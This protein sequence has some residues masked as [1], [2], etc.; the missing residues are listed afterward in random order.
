MSPLPSQRTLQ[1]K[2]DVML[3]RPAG[4][5]G[6]GGSQTSASLEA[7]ISNIKTTESNILHQLADL[8]YVHM[9][10]TFTTKNSCVCVC[11][12][13]MG[14]DSNS[15]A[16]RHWIG[17]LHR[18]QRSRPLSRCSL[19]LRPRRWCRRT[20]ATWRTS[21]NTSRSGD[22]SA[23]WLAHHARL[24]R[25][26]LPDGIA[27]PQLYVACGT[28][29]PRWSA[30]RAWGGGVE[31]GVGLGVYIVTHSSRGGGARKEQAI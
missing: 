11:V 28:N 16:G 5:G 4:T 29:H 9:Y 19:C 3:A 31:R 30:T 1:K 24:F 23:S 25:G 14:L 2:M 21:H 7:E 27:P 17:V 10:N 22:C 6:G 26:T 20:R 12:H 8:R 13:V 15:A 18:V